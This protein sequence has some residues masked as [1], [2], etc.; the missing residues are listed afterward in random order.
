MDDD[1]VP[2]N[3]V[4]IAKRPSTV[5][6]SVSPQTL[7]N[8]GCIQWIDSTETLQRGSVLFRAIFEDDLQAFVQIA[9]LY[10]S[11]PEPESLPT[12]T[13]FW[14]LKYDRRDVLDELI[15][16]SGVG[17]D[18]DNENAHEDEV[19][20][21]T[22]QK[23]S[24]IYLGLNVHGKKRKDLA[25]KNDPNAN[26]QAVQNRNLPLLW[27]AAKAGA[28]RVIA[29]LKGD[30]PLAAYRYYASTH[31]DERATYLRRAP[32]LASMLPQWLGWSM[33]QLNESAITTAILGDNL[34]VLK[35]LLTMQ[36]KEM[37]QALIAKYAYTLLCPQ[38]A[39]V[40]EF[41]QD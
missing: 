9:E 2:I 25:T 16:R 39:H 31:S 29:Y 36:P 30:L 6:T 4:D 19:P 10:S 1:S 37:E 5:K 13:L 14:T 40:T 28:L 8:P 38:S 41:L 15:R 26:R 17:I 32:D 23:S 12:N 7:L 18:V 21:A 20:G 3:F 35:E 34:V 11:L 27:D 22:H 24:K 33:N